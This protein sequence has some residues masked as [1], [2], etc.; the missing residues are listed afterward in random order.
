MGIF[1]LTFLPGLL[2]LAYFIFADRFREPKKVIIITFILGMTIGYPA[3]YLNYY[4][5]QIFSNGNI[6]NDALVGGAFAGALVEEILKFLILYFYIFKHKEFN[7]PMDAIVYGIVAS[8]GFA[9]NENYDYV[10]NLA[11]QFN[12]TSWQIALAR[13]YSAIPMHAACGV[14]MGFYFGQNYFIEQGRSFSLALIVPIII[15]GSYNFLLS[16][17]GIYPQAIVVL[18]IIFCFF[19]H[20]VAKQY[21]SNKD[22]EHEEKLTK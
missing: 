22:K 19:L 8:L 4:I 20:R 18:A 10:Y 12:A 6:I 21:Q 11:E 7:E 15:H 13:S 9:L 3:G 14:I 16:F 2:I 5:E 17:N 1:L